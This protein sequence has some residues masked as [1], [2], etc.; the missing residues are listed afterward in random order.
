MRRPAASAT[1]WPQAWQVTRGKLRE[2]AS[3]CNAASVQSPGVCADTPRMAGNEPSP[4]YS[5]LGEDPARQDAID[6]FVVSLA[7]RVDDLQDCEARQDLQRL[8]E[9]ARELLSES[10]HA[11]Y[12]SLSR[13]AAAVQV[14]AREGKAQD[15]RKALIELTDVAHRIRLGHRGAV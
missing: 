6:A 4:I 8:A 7:E 5:A 12:D 3:D 1:S 2:A 10:T 14:P 13:S 15:A 11:G 9:L